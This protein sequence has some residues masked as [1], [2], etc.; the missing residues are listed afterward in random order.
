M[1]RQDYYKQGLLINRKLAPASAVK[2]PEPGA[3]IALDG[4]GGV[5]VRIEGTPERPETLR[6][7]L[8]QP[9]GIERL[10]ILKLSPEGEYVGSIPQASPGRW[11]VTLESDAWR[12]PTTIFAGGIGE[13]RLGAAARS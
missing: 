7:K 5:R 6:L 12:L 9:A 2:R 13:I 11:I 3:V 8:A 1:L 10:V 4:D